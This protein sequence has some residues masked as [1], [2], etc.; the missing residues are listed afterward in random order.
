MKVPSPVQAHFDAIAPRYDSFKNRNWY[1]YS[2]L[3]ELLRQTVGTSRNVLEVGCGTGEILAALEIQNGIGLDISEAM[4]ARAKEKFADV[5][6]LIFVAGTLETLKMDR[7][8][9]DCILLVDVIE[10]LESLSKTVQHLR[11][12]SEPST[13]VVVSMANPSWEPLLMLIERLGLKMPEGPHWRISSKQLIA[14]FRR[15]GFDLKLKKRYL[16]LPVYVP[17]L[18]SAINRMLSLTPL[19]KQSGLIEILVFQRID[20]ELP[21]SLG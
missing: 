12:I 15:F 21:T 7:A 9:Y 8:D 10:H 18:S 17:F 4:I 11:R 5:G 20:E 19:I 3:K 14:E 1:Y 6:R 13:R 16:H 2:T